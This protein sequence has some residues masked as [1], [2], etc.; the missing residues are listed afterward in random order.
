MLDRPA[1]RAVPDR[2]VPR[3]EAVIDLDALTANTARLVVAAVARLMAVVKADAYGHGALQAA[4]AALRGGASM[5]GLATPEEARRPARGRDRRADAGLALDVR[6]QDIRPAVAAGVDLGV[7]SVAHLD[8]VRA[9]KGVAPWGRPRIHL[10]ID[11]GLGRNG[12]G[13]AELAQLLAAA[14]AAERAGEVRVVAL[15]S[16]LAS[17][18]LPD[19]PSVAEQTRR[20]EEASAAAS[21]AGLAPEFRHLANTG[22]ALLHPA[23]RMEMVRCGIGL[24]GISPFPADAPGHPCRGR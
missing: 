20:F 14:A 24:Y 8:A 3:A 6:R 16:H 2:P 11:T 12:V 23:A 1:A 5:L 17:S 10:K 22:G 13:G 18:E 19:D 4:R 15:M 9:A 21:A 7:S